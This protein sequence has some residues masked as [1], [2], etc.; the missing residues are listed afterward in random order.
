MDRQARTVGRNIR[1]NHCT[2]KQ[3]LRQY[4]KRT[5]I[6]RPAEA[7]FAPGGQVKNF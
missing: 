3:R 7:A 4:G 5:A 6:P 2:V 1:S